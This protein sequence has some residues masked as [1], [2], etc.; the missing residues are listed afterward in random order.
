MSRAGVKARGCDEASD[1]TTLHKAIARL[2]GPK[3]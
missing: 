3:G 2:T 1:V